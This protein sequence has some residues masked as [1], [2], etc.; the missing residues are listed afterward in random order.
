MMESKNRID[1][2]FS[3]G[4]FDEV[5]SPLL[6]DLRLKYTNSGV[7]LDFL[8]SQQGV[9][10]RDY[11]DGGEILLAGRFKASLPTFIYIPMFHYFII[12]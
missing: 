6:K 12:L 8:V 10:T 9:Q 7:M 2:V 5:A 1:R 4:F 11:N 3:V